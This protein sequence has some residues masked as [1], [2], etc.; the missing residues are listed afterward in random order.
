MDENLA[1]PLLAGRKEVIERQIQ[2]LG[3]RMQEG[4][5]FEIADT[6][7]EAALASFAEEFYQLNRR[8]GAFR[9]G[10]NAAIRTN[11]TLLAAMMLRAGV[12]D[13]MLCGRG[14]LSGTFGIR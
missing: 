10:I 11:P 3:L 1:R 2:T 6:N 7:D 12:G 13:G 5:D 9:E 8:K 14:R 4:R